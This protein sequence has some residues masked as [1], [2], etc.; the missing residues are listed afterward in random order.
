MYGSASFRYE[1]GLDYDFSIVLRK[2]FEIGRVVQ[3]GMA[4]LIKEPFF[5]HNT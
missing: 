4:I 2:H 5:T 1:R 3:A